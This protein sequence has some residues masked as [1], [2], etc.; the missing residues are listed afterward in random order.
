VKPFAEAFQT[1]GYKVWY[2]R[3]TLNREAA[4]QTCVCIALRD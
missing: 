3:F 2:E 4:L 1:A